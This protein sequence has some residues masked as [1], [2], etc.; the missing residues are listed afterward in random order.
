MHHK[1]KITSAY[2]LLLLIMMLDV[3]CKKVGGNIKMRYLL[4]M[5][6]SDRG[7]VDDYILPMGIPYI[8]GAMR[9]KGF[10]VEAINFQYIDEDPLEVLKET[11]P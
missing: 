9:A 7:R 3:F 4:V 11:I 2:L 8:N 6:F 10:D 5:Q 1:R